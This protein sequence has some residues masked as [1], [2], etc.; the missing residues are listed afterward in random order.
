M[1]KGFTLV[2]IM[3]VITVLG[4]IGLIAVVAVDKSIKDNNEKLYQIQVSNIE[5]A[6]RIWGTNNLS[7]LPDNK[8]E[9]VS[10]PL[11]LLK[12]DSLIDKLMSGEIKLT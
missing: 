7:Y 3:A 1:K 9:A 11:V 12:R 6:A 8:D 4:I 2:E 10:I 5:D